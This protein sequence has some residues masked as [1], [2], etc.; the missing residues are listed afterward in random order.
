MSKHPTYS[1]NDQ[2]IPVWNTHSRIR[3]NLFTNMIKKY[4]EMFPNKVHFTLLLL[5]FRCVQWNGYAPFKKNS[6]HFEL[7]M[8]TVRDIRLW[9]LTLDKSLVPKMCKMKLLLKNI[10]IKKNM[11]LSFQNSQIILTLFIINV[12]NKISAKK[13][14]HTSH[15]GHLLKFWKK[16]TTLSLDN[17]Y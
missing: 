9:C 3:C 7:I 14:S 15:G 4:P 17:L 16:K 1:L 13:N 5:Y 10:L 2:E 6:N 8:K 12:K 11:H